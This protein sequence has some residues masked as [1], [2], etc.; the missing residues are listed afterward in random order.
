MDFPLVCTD[1]C[2]TGNHVYCFAISTLIVVGEGSS[3][4][5]WERL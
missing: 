1:G 3:S 2:P 4:H 5:K